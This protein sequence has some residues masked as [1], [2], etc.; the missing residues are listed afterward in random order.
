MADFN[1]L[2]I[3]VISSLLMRVFFARILSWDS[4]SLVQGRQF[5]FYGI[6]EMEKIP[7]NQPWFEVWPSFFRATS[8]MYMPWRCCSSHLL[9]FWIDPTWNTFWCWW[10]KM[11]RHTMLWNAYQYRAIIYLHSKSIPILYP[12]HCAYNTLNPSWM[13][14][15]RFENQVYQVIFWGVLKSST[16]T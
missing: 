7:W 6:I 12:V 15:S 16:I 5:G 10:K 13:R 3:C 8:N 11:S 4:Q 14:W 9:H 2:T 1:E